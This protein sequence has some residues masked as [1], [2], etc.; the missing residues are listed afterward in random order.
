MA[1]THPYLERKVTWATSLF[2]VPPEEIQL[3]AGQGQGTRPSASPSPNSRITAGPWSTRLSWA[4]V[5]PEPS[6]WA[7][8]VAPEPEK[9]ATFSEEA[10]HG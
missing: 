1:G 8:K 10:G 4:Q 6:R 7:I 5:L 9:E 2:S 3:L